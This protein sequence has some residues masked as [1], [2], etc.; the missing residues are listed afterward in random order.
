MAHLLT[1]VEKRRRDIKRYQIDSRRGDQLVYRHINR[2]EFNL[3]GLRIRFHMTTQD[4]QLEVM[5]RMKFLRRVLPG[6]HAKEKAFRGWYV[7]LIRKFN[8]HD[9]ASYEAYVHALET[10]EEVRGFREIRYPKME[11]AKKKADGFLKN[12]PENQKSGSAWP[13]HHKS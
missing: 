4:W 6:W 1:S 12:G 11:E 8:Y 2:P 10:P 5:K 9:H 3:L 13:S 7:D